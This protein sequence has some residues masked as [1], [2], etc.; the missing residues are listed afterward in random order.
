M[1]IKRLNN[2][3]QAEAIAKRVIALTEENTE[4]STNRI[5]RVLLQFNR[6]ADLMKIIMEFRPCILNMGL[7]KMSL[8]R[9]RAK[10]SLFA[11]EAC[12]L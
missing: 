5:E 12:G 7:D 1:K 11:V 10:I 3:L 6:K 4:K 9:L 2:P 8:A